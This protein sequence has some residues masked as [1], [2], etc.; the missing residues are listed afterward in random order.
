[1]AQPRGRHLDEHFAFARRIELKLFDH[2]RL[3][4][5]VGRRQAAL[6]QDGGEGLHVRKSTVVPPSGGK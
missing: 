1:M 3:A 6:M 2:E 5:C 4:L